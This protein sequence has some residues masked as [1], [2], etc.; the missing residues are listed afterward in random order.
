M[1]QFP[2]SGARASSSRRPP[3]RPA[4]LRVSTPPPLST[5]TPAESYPRYSKRLKPSTRT[6]TASLGPTYPTIPHT[7]Q[8]LPRLR[9]SNGSP[10][11]ARP[12]RVSWARVSSPSVVAVPGSAP[13]G[14]P[15]RSHVLTRLRPVQAES[16]RRA[17]A[18]RLPV[19]CG[20][21]VDKAVPSSPPGWLE[22]GRTE[23]MPQSGLR[24]VRLAGDGQEATRWRRVLL[25]G[26]G[27]AVLQV[28]T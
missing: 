12:N 7:A 20:C 26:G 4:S 6:E 28:R 27:C 19:V 18:K 3:M 16:P 24:L 22:L 14:A 5:A 10:V 13:L 8:V 15:H 17:P 23:R 2:C 11:I 21:S 1:P 25:E 9:S